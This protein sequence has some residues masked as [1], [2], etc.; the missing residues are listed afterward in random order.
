[1]VAVNCALVVLVSIFAFASGLLGET[2]ELPGDECNE[3]GDACSQYAM[4]L[5]GLKMK[6]HDGDCQDLQDIVEGRKQYGVV[7]YL[8]CL[9][10][11]VMHPKLLT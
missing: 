10:T 4:Q 8:N 11:G 7:P 3:P 1:M 5:R 6:R 2:Q 9:P